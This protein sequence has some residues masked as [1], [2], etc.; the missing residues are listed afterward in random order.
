MRDKSRHGS[1][2]A[3]LDLLFNFLLGF[4]M[5]FVILLAV[6]KVES[7]KPAVED[8]NEFVITV[9]WNDGDDVDL[10]MWIKG[11]TGKIVGFM[12]KDGD[13]LFLQRDDLGSMNDDFKTEN[14]ETTRIP[15]NQEIINIRKIVP[16][17]YIVNVHYYRHGK[18]VNEG[19][20]QKVKVKLIKVNP[21]REEAT[22]N[23]DLDTRGAETTVLVF[24]VFPDGR[25]VVQPTTP[26]PFALLP[27]GGGG[28]GSF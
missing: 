22:V 21:F 10:D 20:V 26:M 11:P 4:V 16:G 3:F 9:N 25:V 12:Q 7:S 18:M 24:E 19:T 14:G 5:L 28:F 1:T 17:T 2:T 13:G 23:V 8:K 27:G 15:L 6:I